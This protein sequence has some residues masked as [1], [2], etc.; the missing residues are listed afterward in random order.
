M[1]LNFLIFSPLRPS[2]CDLEKVTGHIFFAHFVAPNVGTL[3]LIK[4]MCKLIK[5]F[6][7]SL[8]EV[9]NPQD[10]QDEPKNELQDELENNEVNTN[11]VQNKDQAANSNQ[12][13]D[14]V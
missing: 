4:I 7:S 3:Y 2:P 8:T 10:T 14:S 11:Q 6:L 9:D 12:I 13:D 5:S 1:T